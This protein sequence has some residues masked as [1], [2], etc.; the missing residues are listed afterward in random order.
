MN[1]FNKEW[2]ED[3]V[4]LHHTGVMSWREIAKTLKMGKST[5]SDFLR[6]YNTALT[7]KDNEGDGLTVKYP[8]NTHLVIPDSQVKPGVSLD[9][10][11]WIGK[12]I[13]RKMPNTIIHLG[14]FADMESLSLWNKGKRSAEGVRINEDIEAAVKGM[15]ILLAPMRELQKQQQECGEEVYNPRMVILLGNHENRIERYVEDTPEMHGF[16]STDCLCYEE[17]GWEVVPF[18]TPINIDGVN[19]CHYFPNV[20]TGKALTGTALNMLKTIGESFTMG[21]RQTLDVATRF[22][23]TSGRQQFGL[24]AGACYTHEEGYKGVQGNHHWRGIIVKHNV[25]DGSY[26]PLFVSLDWLEKQYGKD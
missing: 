14:D 1:E 11:H 17:F 15:E 20:M 3:A 12:Y 16:L 13:A 22:L 24:I 10:L 2:Q 26:D 18:L 19:Y 6:A 25:H 21:H 5:V 23:P 8:E 4:K 9:Y 7:S